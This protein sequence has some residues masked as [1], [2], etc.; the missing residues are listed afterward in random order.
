MSPHRELLPSTERRTKIVCTLGP[1]TR[2]PEKIDELIRAGMN[3]VRINCSHGT[4]DEHAET[5]RAVREVA[6]RYDVYIPILLD[7]AGPKMRI[8]EIAGG[9]VTL[10]PGDSF[11]LTTDAVVGDYD[12][13][14]INYP[15]LVADVTPGDRILMGD[16]EIELEVESSDGHEARCR[17]VVGGQLK[18]HKGVNAPGVKLREHVPTE[19]DRDDIRFGVEQGVDWFALSFVRSAEEIRTMKR[20]LDELGADTPVVAKIE[21]R[22]ALDHLDEV[23][24]ATDAVM[25]ARGDLGLELPIQDVPL[26]QKDVLR[27]ARAA[28]K[29]VIIATQMLE[30]MIVNP[31]PTRAEATDVA[32]AV[33]DG[34][35]AVMLSAETASGAWPVEAVRTM[36]EIA[37]ASEARVDYAERFHRARLMKGRSI[38][39]AIAHAACY[40]AIETGA[41]VIVCCTRSGQ[42]ARFV[43][44]HRPPAKIAVV[45]PHAETL[46]RTM[47]YWNTHPIR[48]PLE[49]NTDAM[50]RAARRAVL[51]AGLARAGDRIVIVAG[52]PV[53]VPGTTNMIKADTL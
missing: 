34:T 13:V 27:A 31:R 48:I 1:A 45:S 33:M 36:A 53:D 17:V 46:N 52:V 32:N 41:R 37:L 16:G 38:P 15:S 30:S 6:K 24:E 26:V 4:Q 12:R 42:T 5:I 47:L 8:G 2:T 11:V 10:R 50:I 3:V 18:S 43:S 9:E 22:E 19:K 20:L 28:S 25:I 29:P 44:N 7:L 35:D 14:S 40:T 49:P 23:L 51:D 21:K 39:R